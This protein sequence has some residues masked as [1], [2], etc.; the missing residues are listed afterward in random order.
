ML[1]RVPRYEVV[2]LNIQGFK[3]KRILSVDPDSKCIW[4]FNRKMQ[5]KK[6]V[7]LTQLVQ[8]RRPRSLWGNL[9]LASIHPLLP[10]LPLACPVHGAAKRNA[11]RSTA[12]LSIPRLLVP[13]SLRVPRG[14]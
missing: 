3:Q 4:N 8:V 7:P 1:L 12:H 10:P 6:Q 9:I 11:S 5:L 2:K 13:N 14:V